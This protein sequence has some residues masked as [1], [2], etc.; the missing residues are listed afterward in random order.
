MKIDV[1][2]EPPTQTT[3]RMARAVHNGIVASCFLLAAVPGLGAIN[4]LRCELVCIAFFVLAL[5]L[6]L[7][8]LRLKN[9]EKLEPSE[10]SE[11]LALSQAT[12]EGSRYRS[13]VLQ[14]GRHFIRAEL[15][16]LRAW[17]TKVANEK[18]HDALYGVQSSK[19]N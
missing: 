9:L 13:L 3:I 5:F 8:L 15:L 17:T 1:R 7:S 19:L 2:N 14:Q 18:S 11:M 12:P 4:A 6:A 16:A 10:K